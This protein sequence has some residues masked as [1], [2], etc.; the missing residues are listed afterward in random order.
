M[1]SRNTKS[2]KTDNTITL[3]LAMDPDNFDPGSDL[4]SSSDEE[5]VYKP[6]YE[7]LIKDYA[8]ALKRNAPMPAQPGSN[9]WSKLMGSMLY[10]LK[11]V[12]PDPCQKWK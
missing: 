2:K 12:V 3:C 1:D 9:H 5:L 10:E 4:T 6:V 7:T 8:L 11:K